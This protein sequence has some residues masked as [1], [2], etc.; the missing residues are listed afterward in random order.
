MSDPQ[1]ARSIRSRQSL[2]RAGR[3]LIG[4]IGIDQLTLAEAARRANVS[5]GTVYNRFDDRQHL[6]E[7]IVREWTAEVTAAFSRQ[8]AS[9][10]ADDGRPSLIALVRL[11][12][13]HRRFIRQI[14]MR[15]PLDPRVAA[16]VEP[17][18]EGERAL[19]VGDL[20]RVPGSSERGAHLAA[21]MIL[22]TVE[23]AAVRDVTD[24]EWSQLQADLPAVG[25]QILQMNAL[26]GPRSAVTSSA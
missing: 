7:E 16:I 11:F 12:R 23:R 2:L 4:E 15:S 25:L 10:A 14:V 8:R 19:L 21:L 22:S 24:E 26:L 20:R 5:V 13:E 3:E 18:L 6:I 9:A 17:W 1:Q